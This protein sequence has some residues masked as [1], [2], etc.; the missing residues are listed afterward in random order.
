MSKSGEPRECIICGKTFITKSWNHYCC[1]QE[2]KTKRRNIR[3]RELWKR[4]RRL[5]PNFGVRSKNITEFNEFED[6]IEIKIKNKRGIFTS[7]IDK[8]DLNIAK[9]HNWYLDKDGYLRTCIKNKNK[10]L[11]R[12]IMNEPQGKMIDHI[13][14]DKRD[15]RKSNLRI[16]DAKLNAQNINKFN[17]GSSNVRGVSCIN[18]KRFNVRIWVKNKRVHL[19]E[20]INPNKEQLEELGKIYKYAKAYMHPFSLEAKDVNID[21]I[22]DW[23][24]EKI[25]NALKQ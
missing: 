16:C 21:E 12:L 13:N 14:G 25:D 18:G 2:C 8:E 10:S 7:K 4:K 19:K 5:D 9:A 20:L 1:S 23:I 24:K 3:D 15:N 6:Y 17:I 22:P 11:H